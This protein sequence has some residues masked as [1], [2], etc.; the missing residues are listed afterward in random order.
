MNNK[1]IS[2]KY[3]LLTATILSA[4]M[5]AAS[6]VASSLLPTAAFAAPDNG[7]IEVEPTVQTDVPTGVNVN[8]DP[9]VIF[10]EDCEDIDA[11]DE[12][13]QVN[14][15]PAEQEALSDSEVGEG[16]TL[17][18]PDIQTVQE[19]AINHNEDHE[20]LVVIPS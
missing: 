12:T 16:G 7:D 6:P 17:I 3:L 15:Q 19:T 13:E 9:D 5:L 4:M 1:I 10:S 14:D 2:N 18:S 8:V 20:Y 11:S